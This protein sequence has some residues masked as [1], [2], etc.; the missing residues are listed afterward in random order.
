M[1]MSKNN[2]WLSIQLKKL[3]KKQKERLIYSY[4]ICR[5]KLAITE[6]ESKKVN[7]LNTIDS[8]FFKIADKIDPSLA[9]LTKK[10]RKNIHKNTRKEIWGINKVKRKIWQENGC[11]L[12]RCFQKSY[13]SC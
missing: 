6:I 7:L 10:K 12:L 8:G 5:I 11:I 4:L 2:K 9:S 1:M 13:N 3:G